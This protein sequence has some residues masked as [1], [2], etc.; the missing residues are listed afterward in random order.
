MVHGQNDGRNDEPKNVDHGNK[1]KNKGSDSHE[2]QQD[3]CCEP[4]NRVYFFHSSFHCFQPELSKMILFHFVWV[5]EQRAF[6]DVLAPVRFFMPFPHQPS[7]PCGTPHIYHLSRPDISQPYLVPSD[8][9][10]RAQTV[11]RPDSVGFPRRT[12]REG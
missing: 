3:A 4:E 8:V 10:C 9:L 7:R 2:R 1:K 12:I 11:L 6:R 5:N